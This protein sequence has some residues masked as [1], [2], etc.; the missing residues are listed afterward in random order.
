[1]SVPR[2]SEVAVSAE[3][4][5]EQIRRVN[6][7]QPLAG[8]PGKSTIGCATLTQVNAYFRLLF[9]AFSL[10]P[11]GLDM[12]TRIVLCFELLSPTETAAIVGSRQKRGFD[13]A[14][15]TRGPYKD[16]P[17]PTNRA[18]KRFANDESNEFRATDSWA[19]RF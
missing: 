17:M 14:L 11:G 5:P 6:G 4:V 10:H 15:R 2:D 9:R 8:S 1:M 13:S 19:M 3:W 12:G 18:D 16:I 7:Q